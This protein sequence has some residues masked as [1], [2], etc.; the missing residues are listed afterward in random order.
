MWVCVWEGGWG[1]IML[2]TQYNM[3]FL[4]IHVFPVP[5]TRYFRGSVVWK[6]TSKL[7]VSE[8][9]EMVSERQGMVISEVR[10]W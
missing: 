3:Q 7:R 6:Y 9:R 10:G 5:S 4:C 2:S 1:G 8:V